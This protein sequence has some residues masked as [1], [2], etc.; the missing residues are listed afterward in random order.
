MD[1]QA[2]LVGA[3]WALSSRLRSSWSLEALSPSC[4]EERKAV[5]VEKH[6]PLGAGQAASEAAEV[7][8]KLP[9]C[10]NKVTPPG[11][12]RIPLE[13]VASGKAAAHTRQ[14]WGHQAQTQQG[15][16]SVPKGRSLT[17]G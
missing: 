12:N 17:R 14:N 15:G 16:G 5:S 7:L 1:G 10:I 6:A 4:L 2:R 13:R 11:P 9:D 3:A 8:R